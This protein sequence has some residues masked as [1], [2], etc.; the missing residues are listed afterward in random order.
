MTKKDKQRLTNLDFYY[1]SELR[2]G[3]YEKLYAKDQA[4]DETTKAQFV[5]DDRVVF[6]DDSGSDHPCVI[7]MKDILMAI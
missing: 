7:E 2:H 6:W 4:E 3:V 1:I 5:K